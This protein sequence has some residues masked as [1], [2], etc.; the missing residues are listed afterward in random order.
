MKD[1]DPGGRRRLKLLEGVKGNAK[2]TGVRKQ[3]RLWLSRDWGERTDPY[4]LWIGMNP[5]AADAHVNDPT[6][7]RE[8]KY[9]KDILN[10]RRYFKVN[11]MDYRAT[12][13]RDLIGLTEPV[14]SDKNLPVI[15]KLAANAARIV[16]CY[17]DLHP[18]FRALATETID[19]LHAE[20]HELW[21]LGRT[22]RNAAPRH[23]LYVKSDRL[24]VRF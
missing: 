22:L 5:S 11:V 1:H 12:R 24:L 18:S 9:T 19:R 3:Y 23:P 15:V 13:P 16:V 6:V 7:A 4:A 14:R 21:C 10:F 2:Y 8:M 20:G 17:G